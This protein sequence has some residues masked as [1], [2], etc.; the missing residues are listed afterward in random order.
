MQT[1]TNNLR[2][3]DSAMSFYNDHFNNLRYGNVADMVAADLHQPREAQRVTDIM[4]QVTDAALEVCLHPA[5]QGACQA[6]AVSCADN[7]LTEA[8]ITAMYDYLNLYYPVEKKLAY[9]AIASDRIS[10][11]GAT[12][13]AML[14]SYAGLNLISAAASHANGISHWRGRMAYDLLC[15]A[16]YIIRAAINLLAQHDESYGSEKLRT[17]MAR[18]TGALYEAVRH[19]NTAKLWDMHSVYFPTEKDG[20]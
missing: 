19:S 7:N 12:G 11:F 8:T 18:L 13:K 10:N 9:L 15:A 6:L 16:E 1:F 17:A 14:K 4:N 3:S 20:K 2:T 5:H